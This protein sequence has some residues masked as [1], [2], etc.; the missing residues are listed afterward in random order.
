MDEIDR[1]VEQWNRERPDLDVSPTHTLQRITR[2]SLLQGVSFGRVFA[3]YGVT[4][5]EYLVLA[6]L[7]RAGQPYRMNPTRLFNSVILSSGAMTNRLD[8]LEEMGLVERQPDPTDRRGR[9][10][11]LTKRGLE[12]VDTAI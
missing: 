3:R 4:F 6:T 11:A 7:R 9:L 12:L 2:L 5:G 1:I 8:R 10:V